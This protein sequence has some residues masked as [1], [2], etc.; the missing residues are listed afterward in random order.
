MDTIT[1]AYPLAALDFASQQISFLM[2]SAISEHLPNISNLRNIWSEMP[3][4]EGGD[5]FFILS[6]DLVDNCNLW[7]LNVQ[8]FYNTYSNLAD[9]LS[10]GSQAMQQ[11]D[12]GEAAAF[13]GYNPSNLV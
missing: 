12:Q 11:Q 1:I 9:D 13:N 6:N 10:H 7:D 5:T 8:E 3:P 2:A 4:L